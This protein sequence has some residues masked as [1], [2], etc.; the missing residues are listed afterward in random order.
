MVAAFLDASKPLTTH[1]GAVTCLAKLGPLVV[2]VLIIDNVKAYS[3][4]LDKKMK[5]KRWAIVEEDGRSLSNLCQA[6]ICFPLTGPSQRGSS[7]PN[8]PLVTKDIH[9]CTHMHT[10]HTHIH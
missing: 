1:Y 2:D 3:A 6:S 10:A 4:V 5:V 9:V 7:K 8:M